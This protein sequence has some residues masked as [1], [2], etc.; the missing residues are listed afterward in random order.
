MK[1]LKLFNAVIAKKE[2]EAI[3]DSNL[4]IIIDRSA[5]WAAKNILDYYKKEKLS[6]NDL[7]KTFHKSWKKIQD[8]SRVDLYIE[9]ITHYISTYGSNFTAEAYIPDEELKLPK[10]TKLVFKVIK[11]YTKQEMAGKCLALLRSGIALKEETVDDVLSILMDDLQ[12]KFTGREGITNKEAIVK[13]AEV[14]NVYPEN[15]VEF[16]RFVVYRTTNQTLLIKNH[17]L[18]DAIKYSSFNPTPLFNSFGLEK[19][20]QIFNRFKPLFLAYKNRAPKTIN[21]ISKLSKTKHVPL[22]ENPLNLVTTRALLKRDLHWLENATTYALFKALSAC[23][24]RMNGQDV[25]AYRIRNGKSYVK[26]SKAKKSLNKKNYKKILEHLK[27]RISFEDVSVYI[28]KGVIYGLPTSE[29]MFVGNL[30]TGT[31]FEGKRLAA[32]IYWEN[33]WGA[34]DLDLSGLFLSGVKVGWNAR[35]SANNSNILY[36]GDITDAPKGAVEYLHAK[37]ELSSS[38][39]VKHN[40]FTGSDDCFYKII[41]GKGDKVTREYMMNPD[42][43]LAEVKCQGVQKQ[44]ILGI[45]IPTKKGQSFTLLNFGAG[46]V[47]VS[48]AGKVT[49]LYQK[50]LIQQWSKPLSFNKLIKDLGGKIVRDKE[51]ADVDLSLE[52]IEKDTFINYRGLLEDLIQPELI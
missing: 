3:W 21:R 29:K 42:N 15:P 16:F 35:F 19:L 23:Y 12:Y 47:R 4:G 40:V 30:P 44:M 46:Q 6:G 18:I 5:V 9:Q 25:F 26:E 39:L 1:T 50:A 8:S 31:R 28:P 51:E 22:V 20:A 37:S 43:L 49:E 11:G 10:G 45:L 13:L 36:S 34:R 14:Y 24:T 48:G 32:G 2:E 33:D 27:T 17:A 41:V 38:V 7:N 52:L